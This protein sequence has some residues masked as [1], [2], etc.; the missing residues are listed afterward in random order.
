MAR[1][2]GSLDIS[3]IFYFCLGLGVSVSIQRRC[4]EILE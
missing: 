1:E 3:L 4:R 2:R